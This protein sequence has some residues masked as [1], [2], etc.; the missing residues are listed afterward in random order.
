M[1]HA[2]EALQEIADFI[3]PPTEKMG[4]VH[5]LK[6]AIANGNNKNS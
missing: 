2:P 3:A 4:I 6:F 5:A 1:S